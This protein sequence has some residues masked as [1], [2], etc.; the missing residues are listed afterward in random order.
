MRI[1]TVTY[2]ALSTFRPLSF[3]LSDSY[4]SLFW[5]D[6]EKIF[7]YTEP[8]KTFTSGSQKIAFILELMKEYEINITDSIKNA[9]LYVHGEGD[10]YSSFENIQKPLAAFV[11]C[12]DT[13]SARVW[14]EYPK[15][16][17]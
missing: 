5:H 12:C 1:S 10:M 9:I 7:T 17:W 2:D 15:K 13:I 11:H 16:N 8:K 4:T 14:S 6:V 3:S